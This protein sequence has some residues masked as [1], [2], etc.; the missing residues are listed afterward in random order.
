MRDFKLML[1]GTTGHLAI[2][3]DGVDWRP[4]SACCGLLRVVTARYEADGARFS[5]LPCSRIRF[6]TSPST[7]RFAADQPRTDAVGV[8]VAAS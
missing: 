2:P 7:M 8:G 1:H 5:L 3:R 6:D 4:S